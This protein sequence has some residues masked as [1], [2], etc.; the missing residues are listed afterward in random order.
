ML[1][2]TDI[3]KH[4]HAWIFTTLNTQTYVQLLTLSSFT[5]TMSILHQIPSHSFPHTVVSHYA[6]VFSTPAT[7]SNRDTVPLA[8]LWYHIH[9]NKQRD[10]VST[11]QCAC[12]GIETMDWTYLITFMTWW[13]G[14][15]RALL[16]IRAVSDCISV[17]CLDRTVALLRA[18]TTWNLY[19][20]LHY[21]T[22]ERNN[23]KSE[24]LYNR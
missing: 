23:F 2:A 12:A 13:S 19:F 21:G 10:V 5:T 4:S 18:A 9:T 8:L 6:K 22:Y 16:Y 14:N 1:L 20:L 17:F 3:C 15:K 11:W 7:F 24:Y